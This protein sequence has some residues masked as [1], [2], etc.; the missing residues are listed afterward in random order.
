M[1]NRPNRPSPTASRPVHGICQRSVACLSETD[2]SPDAH[3]TAGE[4]SGSTKPYEL[5]GSTVERLL[6]AY[7]DG[8]RRGAREAFPQMRPARISGREAHAAAYSALPSLRLVAAAE[9]E[10]CTQSMS[11]K[12][13]AICRRLILRV[14]VRRATLFED[15]PRATILVEELPCAFSFTPSQTSASSHH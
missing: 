2:A 13:P 15:V 10:K 3:V 5:D 4:I 12:S 7:N 8:G 6:R 9:I 1:E 11:C 14:Y